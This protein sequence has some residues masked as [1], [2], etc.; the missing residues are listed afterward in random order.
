LHKGANLIAEIFV[1][2][3]LGVGWVAT[4]PRLC[5]GVIYSPVRTPPIPGSL[6]PDPFTVSVGS[7]A[8][9]RIDRKFRS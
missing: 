1:S 6:H 3:T 4:R 5:P 7:A 9:F 2:E 8:F